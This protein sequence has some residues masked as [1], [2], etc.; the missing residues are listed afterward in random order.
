[1][2][3]ITTAQERGQETTWNNLKRL[4]SQEERNVTYSRARGSE[5]SGIISGDCR[6]SITQLSNYKRLSSG[7]GM[8]YEMT[9]GKESQSEMQAHGIETRG[10]KG[11]E[12]ESVKNYVKRDGI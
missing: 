5:R 12:H 10:R 8:P 1:M 3:A 11:T 7:K 4:V 6:Y 9:D 2:T